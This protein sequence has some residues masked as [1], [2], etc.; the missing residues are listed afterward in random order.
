M[1][2]SVE[3]LEQLSDAALLDTYHKARRLYAETKFA[4]DTER[5][6]LTWQSARLFVT[7]KGGITER[8]KAAEASEELAKKGQHIRE[9]TRDLDVL[10]ADVA[11]IYALLRLRGVALAAKPDTT[12]DD[13]ATTNA[14]TEG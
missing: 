14:A 10:K 6:R 9:I 11:L 4:R 5:G 7:S 2:V 3:S 1:E 12:P 13:P 8:E